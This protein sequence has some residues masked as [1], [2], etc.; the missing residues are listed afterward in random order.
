M[1]YRRRRPPSLNQAFAVLQKIAE[2]FRSSVYGFV[3]VYGALLL[4]AVNSFIYPAELQR[5]GQIRRMAALTL[6]CIVNIWLRNK[7][8]ALWRATFLGK[9]V[10]NLLKT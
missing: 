4:W 9:H 10:S 6:F 7:C 5:L 2:A 8:R 3:L 1:P